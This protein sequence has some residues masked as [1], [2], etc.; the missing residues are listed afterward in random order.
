[1][2]P[3]NVVDEDRRGLANSMRPV[4]CLHHDAWCPVHFCE[5]HDGGCRQSDALARSRQAEES[6]CT[7]G[8]SLEFLDCLMSFLVIYPP[9][10]PDVTDRFLDN[11]IFQLVQHFVMMSE[12]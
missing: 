4:L 5:D 9:I 11:E 8:V 12:E 7:V 2:L 10:N 1:M 3:V 6:H